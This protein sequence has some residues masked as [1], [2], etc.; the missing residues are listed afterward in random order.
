MQVSSLQLLASKI[1]I[2]M[3]SLA[4]QQ[5]LHYF[6]LCQVVCYLTIDV[7]SLNSSPTDMTV[8]ILYTLIN[9]PIEL[10]SNIT[11]YK[12]TS[13]QISFITLTSSFTK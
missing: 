10:R 6:Y 1:P 13:Q 2:Q 8:R 11:F 7:K 4:G 12:T 5:L 9:G 3:T